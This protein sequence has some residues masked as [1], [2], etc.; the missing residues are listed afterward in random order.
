MSVIKVSVRFSHFLPP[1]NLFLYEKYYVA[2]RMI[3]GY[4][5]AYILRE[6]GVRI[7]D[8]FRLTD[9]QNIAESR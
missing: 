1:R 9:D 4:K 3:G 2:K 8:K 6:A 7:L 5:K